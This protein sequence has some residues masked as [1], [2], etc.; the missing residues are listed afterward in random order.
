MNSEFGKENIPHIDLLFTYAMLITGE[1]RQ[2]EK[3]LLQTFAK[4]YWFWKHLSE[5]TDVKLW[6]IRIMR[7]IF[8][9][10]P[11]YSESTNLLTRKNKSIDVSSLNDI[12][13]YNKLDYQKTKHLSQLISSLPLT[14]KDVIIFAD[15]L[16]LSYELVADLTEV[17]QDV[18]RKR[19]FNARQIVLIDLLENKSNE[20]SVSDSQVSSEDKL[21]IINSVDNNEQAGL[22]ENEIKVQSF[23][24]NIINNISLPPVRDRIKINLVN[25]YASHLKGEIEKTPSAERRSIVRVATFAMIVLITI[26]ILLF[27][28]AQENPAEFAAQQVGEDNI[29]VHL[30]NNYSLYLDGNYSSDMKIGDESKIKD[31]L[32]TAGLE[33]KSILP[34]F[35][36]WKVKNLYITSCKEVRLI[37]L[38]YKNESGAILYL[39]QVPLQLVDKMKIIKLTPALLDYL[40]TNKC[41]SSREGTTYYI[42]KK[43]KSHI[44]GFALTEPRKEELIEICGKSYVSLF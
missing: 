43:T 31:F 6:L 20:F 18:V 16:K 4:A 42:L 27:R 1:N 7:N 30:K 24:K 26:L 13:D 34:K 10:N 17:P 25:K 8:L 39:Y 29:L 5:E 32:L 14:L 44:L 11:V 3:I 40:E 19:L 38:I 22:L 28:P 9:T 37:N 15:V 41:Y 36:G 23:V 12:D 35:S 2:A 33:Y 21:L